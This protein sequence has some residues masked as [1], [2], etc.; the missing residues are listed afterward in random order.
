MPTELVAILCIFGIAIIL[1]IRIFIFLQDNKTRWIGE[2]TITR[3][4]EA[5][6]DKRQDEIDR[7][8]TRRRHEGFKQIN[9]QAKQDLLGRPITIYTFERMPSYGDKISAVWTRD[10]IRTFIILAVFSISFCFIATLIVPAS[11][12]SFFIGL[13]ATVAAEQTNS[14]ATFSIISTGTERV[15]QT[16]TRRGQVA[17]QG[18]A[19]SAQ[20]TTYVQQTISQA[21]SYVQATLDTRATATQGVVNTQTAVIR[22][23]LNMQQTLS[24]QATLTFE[25]TA[26]RIATQEAQATAN[27]QATIL[28]MTPTAL[29]YRTTTG[30]NIRA[31]P[32]TTCQLRGSIRSGE[33]VYVF[34]AVT[35]ENVNGIT[36]WYRIEYNGSP[37]Y[38]HSS[39]ARR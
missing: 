11:V 37:G 8:L 28:A 25:A 35:G 24:A 16:Q 13:T 2:G 30:A 32:E 39:T 14:Q 38:I 22:Q 29:P 31:C 17:A 33:T 6:P 20:A 5:T 18:T 10:K 9:T 15:V 23:T 3:N 1:L 7:E 34:Q 4:Y 27:A 12:N 36:I 21:T 19:T 26:N